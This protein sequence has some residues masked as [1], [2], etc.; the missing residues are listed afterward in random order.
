MRH[1]RRVLRG[2]WTKLLSVRHLESGPI[3]FLRHKSYCTRLG[4]SLSSANQQRRRAVG[5][6][7]TVYGFVA[8]MDGDW[9]GEPSRWEPFTKDVPQ[10]LYWSVSRSPVESVAL[11]SFGSGLGL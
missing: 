6:V 11:E 5:A 9:S 7:D 10:G 2:D 4:W 1:V 3:R 8:K